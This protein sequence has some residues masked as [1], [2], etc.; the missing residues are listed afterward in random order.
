M[1]SEARVQVSIFG[2]DYRVRGEADPEHIRELAAFVDRTMKEIAAGSRQ[3]SPLRIAILAAFNIAAE[4]HR[5]R[6]QQ[7]LPGPAVEEKAARLLRLFDDEPQAAAQAA[8]TSQ[9]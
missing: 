9:E 5:V 2:H 4:L 1:S 8:P 6:A 3:V 7:A